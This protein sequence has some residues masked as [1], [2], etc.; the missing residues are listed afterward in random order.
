MS[1]KKESGADDA[2]KLLLN[3]VRHRILQYIDHHGNATV[4]EMS[5]ALKD[6]PQAT[7]YRQVKLLN[8]S[9]LINVCGQRQVRGTLE[10]TYSLSDRLLLSDAS[11]MMSDE[12]FAE[13]MADIKSLT[14]RY[15]GNGPNAERR[16]RRVTL[17]SSPA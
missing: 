14:S 6:I 3:Q 15:A 2:Q 13:Y 11:M 5:E 10:H 9:G 7:L 12:E 17:I 4:R 8:E 16:I 1:R